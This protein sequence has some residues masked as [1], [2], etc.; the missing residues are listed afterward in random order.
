MLMESFYEGLARWQ[1][2][3]TASAG[4][5]ATLAG[6]LFVAL[7]L[8]REKITAQESRLLMRHAQRS[9]GDFLLALFIALLFLVPVYRSSDLTISLVFPLAF[10]GQWLARSIYRT[11]KISGGKQT[12]LNVAREYLFQALSWIVLLAAC[13]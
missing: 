2:F 11:I 4:V 8:N 12:A 9:F 1:P 10:R 7:S 6:L 3:F 13:L 5:A